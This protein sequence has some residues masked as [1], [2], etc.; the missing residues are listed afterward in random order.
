MQQR[1]ANYTDIIFA[2]SNAGKINEISKLLPVNVNII[3]QNTLGIGTKISLASEDAPTFVENALIKARLASKI[4][5]CPSIADDSGLSVE[6]LHGAPGV[7]TARFAGDNATDEDNINKLLL[8]LEGVPFKNRKAKFHCV[9]VFINNYQ[10]PSPLIAHACWCGYILD[11][12]HG[13]GGFGYDPVF[14]LQDKNCTSAELPITEKNIL[15][16]RGQACRKLVEM[17]KHQG[18]F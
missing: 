14:Y 5:G 17:I 7:H 12:P 1:N 3:P 16:H 15:S 18:L 10:D 2:S 8:E 4:S 9:L 11:K 13:S 6:Y